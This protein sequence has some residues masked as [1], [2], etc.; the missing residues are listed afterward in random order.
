MSGRARSSAVPSGLTSTSMRRGTGAG[1]DIDGVGEWRR[2]KLD[3]HEEVTGPAPTTYPRQ[4]P[5]GPMHPLFFVAVAHAGCAD[6]V[7][8]PRHDEPTEIAMPAHATAPVPPIDRD[9][10]DDIRTVVFALG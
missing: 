9:R 2:T 1:R 4:L 5:G 7:C 3:M 8:P 10:P 6:G